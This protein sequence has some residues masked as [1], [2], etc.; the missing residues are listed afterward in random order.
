MRSADERLLGRIERG[1]REV[2]PS[3]VLRQ[4]SQPPI[5]GAALLGLDAVGA[6][7]AAQ[8]RVRAELSAAVER[9]ESE[10]D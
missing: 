8:A 6:S 5:V 9:L 10:G 3:I 2:S 1:L 7:A 4:T